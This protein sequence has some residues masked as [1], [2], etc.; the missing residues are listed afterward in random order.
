MISSLLL[1]FSQNSYREIFFLFFKSFAYELVTYFHGLILGFC[2]I[3][4]DPTSNL[5]LA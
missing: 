1:I 2:D 3:T 5:S 4:E